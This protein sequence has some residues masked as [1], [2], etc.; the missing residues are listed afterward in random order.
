MFS[1]ANVAQMKVL[2]QNLV[3][4]YVEDESSIR[5][6]L[7]KYFKKFFNTVIV[8]KD[9]IEG[10]EAYKTNHIDIVAT[11]IN[12]PKMNGLTMA[13]EIKKINEYQNILVVSA[14]S[15]VQNFT[16]SIQIGI[17]G[18]ILKPIDYNQLN[19][20]LYKI[21]FK[22]KQFQENKK[23]KENLEELVEEKTHDFKQLQEEQIDNYKKTLHALVKM[24]EDRDT[25]TGGHSLRVAQY[26]KMIAKHL[27]LDEQ[28][29]ENIYEAG[30]LH[31][32]GKIAIP[33]NILLKPGELNNLEY[34]LI[35]EHVNIGV[36]MLEKI[37]MFEVL[38]QY[39]QGHHERLDGSGYPNGLQG[40]AIALESQILAVSDTFDAMTTS[41]IY[42]AR[43]S[44]QE[45]LLEIENL[46]GIY[47]KKEVVQSAKEVLKDIHIDENI[48]QFPT[49]QIEKERFS[50][51]YKDQVMQCYNSDYLDLMLIK[52][53]HNREYHYIYQV[54]IHHIDII[55][56]RKGWNEGN[57]YLLNIVTHLSE[58][59][60]GYDIFHIFG[61]DFVILSKELLDIKREILEDFIKSNGITFEIYCYDIVKENIDSL[62]TLEIINK[63]KSMKR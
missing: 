14:Y 58:L 53:N 39:I 49:T 59:F 23:Y 38:A 40:D 48:T 27:N 6:S 60:Q 20:T 5:E 44:S 2:T 25:Y 45:A 18:Y 8:A 35:Q 57:S 17:D 42:K 11:D 28:K 37:P 12:M 51:F 16:E 29:C 43:K 26:S 61:D 13:K 21:A 9:G 32:I 22:I 31:D 30:I 52:N 1:S 47:F 63:A 54:A 36:Q 10:L 34:T 62:R 7:A 50:Y 56:E 19:A 3:I 41:R 46:Q 33:D 4:L 55:N 24:I 15:D